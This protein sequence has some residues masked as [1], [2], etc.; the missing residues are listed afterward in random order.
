MPNQGISGHQTSVVLWLSIDFRF[1]E[2]SVWRKLVQPMVRSSP[3]ELLRAFSCPIGPLVHV[4]DVEEIVHL[5]TSDQEIEGCHISQP[6]RPRRLMPGA[7][8]LFCNLP[9]EKVRPL[10][11]A[12]GS[13]DRTTGPTP[14]ITAMSEINPNVLQES[15]VRNNFLEGISYRN[16]RFSASSSREEMLHLRTRITVEDAHDVRDASN[17]FGNPPRFRR[18]APDPP[19]APTPRNEP[20][21]KPT[22]TKANRPHPKDKNPNKKPMPSTKQTIPQAENKAADFGT[23]VFRVPP[24]SDASAALSRSLAHE[25]RLSM[26]HI[27]SS[28]LVACFWEG[29]ALT[30][31]DLCS[32]N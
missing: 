26:T 10:C 29:G 24:V 22:N 20:D 31:R 17:E 1:P 12:S 27:D 30:S 19:L 6:V 3:I 4:D 15:A 32:G 25:P 16:F 14:L 7:S 18:I 23:Q 11:H 9:G 21:V 8:N 2:S 5:N 28:T 13:A